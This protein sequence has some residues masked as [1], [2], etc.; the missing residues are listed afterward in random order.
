[1]KIEKCMKGPFA[2]I[3]REGIT[4]EGDGFI[5]RLWEY[6]NT[7]F[8]EVNHLAKRNGQGELLGFWGAMSDVTRSFKPWEDNFT[9]GLYLAGVECEDDAE[10]PEGWVKW[11]IPGYEYL[12]VKC[13]NTVATF[14]EV[15]NYLNESQITLAGAVNDYTCP[16][17]GESYMFFPIRKL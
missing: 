8:N 5:Q 17:T 11:L 9:R 6:A 12:Y 4:S 15:I 14:S 1:M 13:E 7:H 10:P 16:Q 3:G 2:V